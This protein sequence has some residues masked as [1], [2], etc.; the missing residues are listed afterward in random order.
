MPQ[1]SQVTKEGLFMLAVVIGAVGAFLI[2]GLLVVF[3]LF[4]R[5]TLD[6]ILWI[7]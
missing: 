2:I 5:E 7:N 4:D 3:W 1:L 6:L